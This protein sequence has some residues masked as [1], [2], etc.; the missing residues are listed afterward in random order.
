MVKF[1]DE[2]VSL[3]RVVITSVQDSEKF[4]QVVANSL[5]KPTILKKIMHPRVYTAREFGP[6]FQVDIAGKHVYI[7]APNDPWEMGPQGKS[8]RVGMVAQ[9]AN[10]NNVGEVTAVLPDCNF[11]RKERHERGTG[12]SLRFMANVFKVAGID[13]VLTVHA[14]TSRAINIFGEV[15]FEQEAKKKANELLLEYPMVADILERHIGNRALV[16]FLDLTRPGK[17]KKDEKTGDWEYEKDEIF[18]FNNKTLM[19]KVNSFFESYD[20]H[21][22]ELGKTVF[23]DLDMAPLV[24]HYLVTESMLADRIDFASGGKN[25]V[26]FYSDLGA[27]PF[28]ERIRHYLG[29]LGLPNVGYLQILKL[30]K[31]PNDPNKIIAEIDLEQSDFGGSLENK[32]L[33][34]ADD[35]T[36]SGGTFDM[37]AKAVKAEEFVEKFGL[38][39]DVALYFTQAWM[40]G[41][42]YKDPQDLLAGINP[43]EIITTNTNTNIERHLIPAFE[44][45]TTTLRLARYIAAAIKYGFEGGRDLEDVF[46]FK[47][48]DDLMVRAGLIYSIKRS[49][50]L[51]PRELVDILI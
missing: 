25:L 2:D 43:I 34:G 51:H 45:R 5:G 44:G 23:Y 31:A 42:N 28:G 21:T 8:W 17:R 29:L 18:D 33:F 10:D 50:E 27:R 14:H 47:T 11:T 40:S 3:E 19:E 32:Y 48:K 6:K 49:R 4:A 1:S 7:I 12:R 30:R 37:A 24:A 46:A 22:Y 36:D 20:A 39:V 35:G 9:A 13:R 26:L 15:Y 41:R 38:P 16:D